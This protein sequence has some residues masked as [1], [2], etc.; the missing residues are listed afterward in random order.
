MVLSENP[1]GDSQQ[2][3][4]TQTPILDGLPDD[5][6][7]LCLA[8]V[9]RRYHHLLRGVCK[10]W[11]ALVCSEDWFLYR[12]N[13]GLDETWIYVLFKDQFGQLCCYILDP[14]RQCWKP[15]QGITNL[16]TRFSK[17]QGIACGVLGR[18]MYL[19]GGCGWFGDVSDEVY[20]YDASTNTWEEATPLL[21]SR[22]WGVCQV[23]NGQL[24]VI[25]GTGLSSALLCSW[26][27]YD[28]HSKCW[29]SHVD[30]NVVA[31]IKDSVVLDGKIYI[32]RGGSAFYPV[33]FRRRGVA[34][35][36]HVESAVYDPSVGAWKRVDDNMVQG[37][38]GPAV[39]VDGDLYVLDESSGTKLKVWQ[40]E[41]KE[42]EVVGRLSTQLTRPPCQLVAIGRQIFVIGRGLSTVVI[43]LDRMWKLDDSYNRRRERGRAGRQQSVDNPEESTCMAKT[44]LPS[45]K[46]DGAMTSKPG[47]IR[48]LAQMVDMDGPYRLLYC[49]G[50]GDKDGVLQEIE[51]GVSPNLADYDKR[52]ALHLASCEG[53]TQ[54][55]DLLIDKGADVNSVDR[56]GR[57][58][59]SDARSFRH[60]DICR[61]LEKRGAID[62]VDSH[63]PCYE[64]DHTEVEMAGKTLIGEGA[65]G[66]VYRVKWRGTEVAAKTIRSSI[67]SDDRVR[68]TFK[69]E[70]A[71]WQTLRHPNIVQFLGVLNHPDRL[72]FLTEYL[73][74]GSL[75]D[76]LRRK[77]RLDISTAVAYAL[78]IARG[79]N[80][81]HQHKPHAIVHRDLTPRN[82]LQDEAGRLKV[83][84]FGLSKIAQEKDAYRYK[85]T[86]GT[87]SYRYMAPEVY[88]RESY[89]K[90]V[91][92]FSFA[93]I[94]HELGRLGILQLQMFQ[95][96][97]SNISEAP[98]AVADR[99]AYEDSRPSLSSY[100]YPDPIKSLLR[101][102]WH[103]EPVSRPSFEGIITKLEEI[104]QSLETKKDKAAGC[105]TCKGQK[106]NRS[107]HLT[108]AAISAVSISLVESNPIKK[109]VKMTKR[110]DPTEPLPCNIIRSV[111]YF[112]GEGGREQR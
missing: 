93:V 53:C 97:T 104:Q 99:R 7:L 60:E 26:D 98:E 49:S 8:R 92:V 23:L 44:S 3:V 71:L 52:T 19:L 12:Q 83:T 106:A 58:P 17:R 69:K 77:G 22:S 9:P 6:A 61:I 20:C 11:R 68:N 65:Y 33:N 81:L 27:T 55:V 94:M 15:P 73:P 5:L 47:S 87:G 80:Y 59:L 109:N 76:I 21:T 72:I 38:Q 57:T 37:W 25:G 1:K 112:D 4:P 62:P 86:G 84:D 96:R 78:D 70:L 95:G 41:R 110:Q 66:E 18:K 35:S 43:D 40:K 14:L 36:S 46:T 32:R 82:V 50:K 88:R 48:P 39:V 89:G 51:K 10:R 67:A 74:N 45:L 56:W 103:K 75:F 79:M 91:D 100:V 108:Y 42:W 29:K 2:I 90:S 85:M 31:G 28:P 107:G 16:P 30:P 111:T 102:C 63:S 13:H 54:I 101:D 34:I 105:C 24:H 64:I